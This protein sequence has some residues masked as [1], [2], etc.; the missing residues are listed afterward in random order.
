MLI[1][2]NNNNNEVPSFAP[3]SIEW[4]SKVRIYIGTYFGDCRIVLQGHIYKFQLI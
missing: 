2:W 4:I 3:E 1:I